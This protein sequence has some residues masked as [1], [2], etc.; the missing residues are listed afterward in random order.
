MEDGYICYVSKGGDLMAARFDSKSLALGLPVRMTTGVARREF[1]GAALFDI[2]AAGQLVYASGESR[3]IGYLVRADGVR[4]DT[5]PFGRLA[6]LN[7][8]FSPDG[9]RAAVTVDGA[10]GVELRVFDLIAN[11]QVVWVTKPVLSQ[12]IWSAMGDR[13]LF[14]AGD[15]LFVGS[16]DLATPPQ[17]AAVF[18]EPFVPF[19]WL[20]NGHVIGLLTSTNRVATLDL[21]IGASSLRPLRDNASFPT[22]SPNERWLMYADAVGGAIWVEPLPSTGKRFVAVDLG[23]GEPLWRADNEIAVGTYDAA[24]QYYD[25]VALAPGQERPLGAARRWITLQDFRD[26]PGPSVSITPDGRIVYLQGAREQPLRFLRVVPSWTTQVRAAVD[27]A[28]QR[29]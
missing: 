25:R 1:T 5:L 18:R 10:Q 27:S 3:A 28:E 16:P 23:A 7:S 6:F 9:K 17:V 21:V 2:S 15:T 22:V 14:S 12:P 20:K 29:R 8:A 4:N 19:H 26:T 24:G 13:L 11:R